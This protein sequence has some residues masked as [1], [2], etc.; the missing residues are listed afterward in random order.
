M[1]IAFSDPLQIASPSSQAGSVGVD[2]E[3]TFS[4][5]N[6][7]DITG[8]GGGTGCTSGCF[9]I[10]QLGDLSCNGLLTLTGDSG[11]D[12]TSVGVRVAA[13][14]SSGVGITID[15]TGEAQ[16]APK[17]FSALCVLRTNECRNE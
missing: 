7:L 14:L 6:S 12:A 15:G 5:A 8:S 2:I 13:Q 3:Q 4:G 17:K 11:G 16:P 9:G 10:L 1:G